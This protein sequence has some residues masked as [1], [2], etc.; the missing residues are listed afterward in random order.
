MSSGLK[1]LFP[2]GFQEEHAQNKVAAESIIVLKIPQFNIAHDKFVVLMTTSLDGDE[3]CAVCINT[4][5]SPRGNHVVI[6][7]KDYNFLDYNSH[8]D[9]GSVVSFKK[10]Y[11]RELLKAEPDRYKGNLKEAEYIDVL[12]KLSQSETIPQELIEKF[13]L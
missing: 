5:P 2:E 7:S 10:N 1:D 13:N 8:I 6:K 12:L 9:C 11:L 4:N 3:I